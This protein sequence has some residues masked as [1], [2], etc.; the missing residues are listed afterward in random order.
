MN[1]D[2]LVRDKIAEFV[3]NNRGE[4][5]NIRMASPEEHRKLLLDKIVE[6]A[7]EVA[8]ACN[9]EDLAEE[10]ADVLEVI[11]SIAEKENIVDL[12]FS[13]RASKLLERGGFDKGIVLIGGCKK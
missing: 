3:L 2:K 9:R 5:L 13:K 6:E 12:V 8:S 11:K 10:L 4:V 7:H 1:N